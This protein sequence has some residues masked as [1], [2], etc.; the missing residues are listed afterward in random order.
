[1]TKK[2]RGKKIKPKKESIRIISNSLRYCAR[3]SGQQSH[4][5]ADCYRAAVNSHSTM[6]TLWEGHVLT[7]SPQ[8]I[9]PN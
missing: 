4:N 8:P 6:T 9:P 3:S 5:F 7:E 2:G 1:M